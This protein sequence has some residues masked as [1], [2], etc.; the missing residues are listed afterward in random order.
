PNATC[1]DGSCIF[2]CPD[3]GNCDDGDC[4]NGEEI[5]DG[6]ICECITINI[7]DPSTCIDDGDCTNGEE[8]WD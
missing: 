4:T 5:W 3:P 6:G 2:T 1:D 8:I 7:P